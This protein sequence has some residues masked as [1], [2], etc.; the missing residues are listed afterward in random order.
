MKH[1]TEKK[2][3]ATIKCWL[4]MTFTATEL[5]C[6]NTI[7]YILQSSVTQYMSSEGLLWRAYFW[8]PGVSSSLSS[9]MIFLCDRVF[10]AVQP[11]P[12]SNRTRHLPSLHP[13]SG[14]RHEKFIYLRSHRKPITATKLEPKILDSKFSSFVYLLDLQNSFGFPEL[15]GC[16]FR[17]SSLPTCRFLV[18]SSKQVNGGSSL[19][20]CVLLG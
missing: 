13:E 7:T 14:P 5:K 18:R 4:A 17:G 2:S 16:P 9:W 20:G 12:T 10:C 19:G 11:S 6:V 15:G 1:H 3:G 8:S